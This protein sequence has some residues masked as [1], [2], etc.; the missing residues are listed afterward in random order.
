MLGGIHK[1]MNDTQEVTAGILPRIDM[2][3]IIIT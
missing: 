2:Y 1:H 3:F